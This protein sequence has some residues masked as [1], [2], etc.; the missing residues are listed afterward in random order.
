[1]GEVRLAELARYR[2]AFKKDDS[3][4]SGIYI[5]KTVNLYRAMRTRGF[6]AAN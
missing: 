1:V 3:F 2:V 5:M 6:A 4:H